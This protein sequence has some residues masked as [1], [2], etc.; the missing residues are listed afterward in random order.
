MDNEK[1]FIKGLT[2]SAKEIYCEMLLSQIE[3]NGEKMSDISIF[4]SCR[5]EPGFLFVKTAACAAFSK[6]ATWTLNGS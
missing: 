3:L 1:N 5:F 6:A 4:S 2:K